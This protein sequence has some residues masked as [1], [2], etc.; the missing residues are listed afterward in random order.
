MMGKW[1]KRLKKTLHGSKSSSSSSSSGSSSGSESEDSEPEI[2]RQ[3]TAPPPDRPWSIT[4]SDIEVKTQPAITSPS[5]E[6]PPIA[7][8]TKMKITDGGSSYAE[9]LKREE[10]RPPWQMLKTTDALPPRALTVTSVTQSHDL[11]AVI[12]LEAAHAEGQSSSDWL[13]R[14]SIQA[15]G[16]SFEEIM[17][18]G[19]PIK[20]PGGEDP[21]KPHMKYDAVKLQDYEFKITNL[22]QMCQ[23]R[24]SWLLKGSRRAFGLVKGQN[25]ALLVDASDSNC[26]YGRL[27]LFQESL[28]ELI[29]EQLVNKGRLFMVSFGTQPK[30]LWTVVRDVNCRM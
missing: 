28:S 18:C 14:H 19:I 15:G 22:I 13:G 11:Q 29:N 7:A 20:P 26:G 23:Q 21:S 25:V 4:H 30:A 24:I 27:Q 1:K 9:E 10:V 8:R 16:L 12:G 6:K 2:S 5:K 3:E 17:K